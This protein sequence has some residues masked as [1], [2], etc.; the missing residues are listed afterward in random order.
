MSQKNMCLCAREA[1]ARYGHT[2]AGKQSQCSLY[3]EYASCVGPPGGPLALKDVLILVVFE[4]GQA[5][6]KHE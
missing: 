6:M 2:N 1:P 3:A 4:F 5:V